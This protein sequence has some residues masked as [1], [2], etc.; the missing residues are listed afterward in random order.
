MIWHGED[1]SGR[2]LPSGSYIYRVMAGS[3]VT[4]GKMMFMK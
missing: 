2:I 3:N 4:T 1:N